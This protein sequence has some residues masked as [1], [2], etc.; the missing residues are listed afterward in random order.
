MSLQFSPYPKKNKWSPTK[1]NLQKENNLGLVDVYLYGSTSLENISS[2][3][4]RILD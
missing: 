4:N 2:I 1:E 3:E